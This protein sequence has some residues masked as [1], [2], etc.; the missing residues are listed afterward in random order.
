MRKKH[1]DEFASDDAA[2]DGSVVSKTQR[3]REMHELQALGERLLE[4]NNKQLAS[5]PLSEA[6]LDAVRASRSITKHEARRRHLQFI[7]RLMRLE[8][9]EPIR[10]KLREWDG[11]SR[12]ATAEQHQLERWRMRLMDEEGALAQYIAANQATLGPSGS[13]DTQHLRLLIRKAREER[14]LGRAPRYF[15]E[16]FKELKRIAD[17][18]R[19]QAAPAGEQ[20]GEQDDHE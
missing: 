5:L 6:L 17:G 12:E 9:P 18:G 19:R 11:V 8:D 15:R 4:L 7:G 13:M 3:K 20:A 14:E 2:G 16:L 1:A 10:E